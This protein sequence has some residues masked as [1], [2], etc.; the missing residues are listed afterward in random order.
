ME[1]NDVSDRAAAEAELASLQAQRAA[2]ADRAM[3]PWWY[4][5][6]LGLLLFGFISSYALH[7]TWVTLAALVVFLLSLR[8]MVALYRRL[9]GFWVDGF[10]RGPTR[11]AIVVWVVVVLAVLGAGF[12]ADEHWRGAMVAAGAVLGVGVAAVSRWW[13]RLYVAELRGRL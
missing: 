9:T 1:S 7:D 5:A 2:L 4:D 8:G 10:R 13:T 12:A 6:L 3:Q 11:R